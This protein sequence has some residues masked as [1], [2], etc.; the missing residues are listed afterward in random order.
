MI[1]IAQPVNRFPEL[2]GY[3][4]HRLKTLCPAMGRVK[5]AQI[6]ARAGLHLAPTTVRRT[7]REARPRPRP[8]ATPGAAS[9][10]ITARKPNDLWHVDLTTVPTALGFWIPWLPFALPQVWPFSWWVAIAVDHSSR[11]VMG[12]AVFR[13]QPASV[14]VRGFLK[15]LFREVGHKPRHLVTDQGR[16]FTAR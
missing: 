5:I 15:R 13:R 8:A 16:Q 4:V 10:T 2:V 9:R 14:A 3:L 7:L 6:L 11:R 12:S 1:Q